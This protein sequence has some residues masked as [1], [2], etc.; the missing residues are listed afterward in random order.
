[1]TGPTVGKPDGTVLSGRA[2]QKIRARDRGHDY[3]E[4][5]LITL[6]ARM[7][8]AGQHPADWLTRALAEV[9]RGRSDIRATSG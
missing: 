7:P 9:G 8:L 1:M 4:R 3:T 2:T 5:A 6:G